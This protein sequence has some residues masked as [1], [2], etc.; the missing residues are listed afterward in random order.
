MLQDPRTNGPFLFSENM[1]EKIPITKKEKLVFWAGAAAKMQKFS[2]ILI[3]PVLVG[4]LL[5]YWL[6][7]KF[8]TDPYL[9]FIFGLLGFVSSI[10]YLNKYLKE[11]KDD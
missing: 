2:S 9:L 1:S 5:G 10:Y 11:H 4:S 8:G 3:G 6:D 7:G